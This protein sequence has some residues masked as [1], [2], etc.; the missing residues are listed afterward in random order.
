MEADAWPW[1]NLPA[2]SLVISRL[3]A[4]A[5]GS[6]EWRWLEVC[7]SLAAGRGDVLSDVDAALGYGDGV[8]SDQLGHLA[9]LVVAA[10]GTPL[11]VLV[12][13]VAGWSPDA[14]RCA[15][16]Y[17]GGVQLDLVVMPASRRSGLPTGAVAVVDKDGR[18]AEPWRPPVEE[19]PSPAEAREWLLLAW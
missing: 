6:G 16:I 8:A 3:E 14:R 7:C 4:V 17:E 13:V 11:D 15:A 19:P 1:S 5:E 18:L 10:A 12:H 9:R 2:H